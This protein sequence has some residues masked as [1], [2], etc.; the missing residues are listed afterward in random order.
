VAFI[1]FGENWHEN[2]ISNDGKE[3]TMKNVIKKRKKEEN[4]RIGV[5]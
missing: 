5:Y 1:V 2:C 4:W 3:T